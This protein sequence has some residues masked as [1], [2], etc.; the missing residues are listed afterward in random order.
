MSIQTSQKVGTKRGI[1]INWMRRPDWN[2]AGRAGVEK[3]H[4]RSY[5]VAE[6]WQ[7]DGDC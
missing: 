4:S 1:P 6:P 7:A 3:L 2:A 5:N